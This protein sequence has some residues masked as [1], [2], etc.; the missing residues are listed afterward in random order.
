M[1]AAM[2]A[3]A[4]QTAKL[5]PPVDQAAREEATAGAQWLVYGEIA[6]SGDTITSLSIGLV[7]AARRGDRVRVHGY[8]ADVGRCFND[9]RN[10]YGRIVALERLG[11]GK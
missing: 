9:A 1:D 5:A 10:A 3:P 4:P 8:L 6:G 7:E 11:G 2:N